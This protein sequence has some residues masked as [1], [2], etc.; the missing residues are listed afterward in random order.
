MRILCI[1]PILHIKGLKKNLEKIGEIDIFED[2]ETKDIIGIIHKYDAIFTNP[3]K[4]KVFLGKDL[5]KHAI[6]LKFIC[7]A[8]TGTVHIDK[9]YLKKRKIKL[10][11]LTKEIK[12]LEKISSTSEHAFSLMLASLRNIVEA[13]RSVR[14]HRWDYEPFI[15]RQMN[16]LNILVI[17]F[18]R[19]GK[20]FANYCKAFDSKVFVY[21][22]YEKIPK[23]YIKVKE[24]KEVLNKVNIISIHVHVN[25]STKYLIDKKFFNDFLKDV[26]IINTS[27]GEIINEKDLISFLKKNKKAK[28]SAD[29]LDEEIFGFKKSKLFKYSLKSDQVLLT[30]HIGGMTSDAQEIAY[31]HAAKLLMTAFENE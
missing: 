31:N 12:V 24:L 20:K 3:N 19:L 2:P 21:D 9:D 1:T 25:K 26:L 29:V 18:G 13:N 23:D 4:S 15:G 17:G 10:I 7:T 11:S 6:K 27:R 30:P 14:N 16:N 22:P 5:L 28:I 8:S